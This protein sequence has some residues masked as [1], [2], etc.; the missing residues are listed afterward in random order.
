MFLFLKYLHIIGAIILVGSVVT[1][2]LMTLKFILSRKN[3]GLKIF[4]SESKFIERGIIVPSSIL[5]LLSGIIMASLWFGWPFWMDW[6]IIVIAFTG[7]TGSVT[8]PKIKRQL[9]DLISNGSSNEKL[10]RRLEFKFIIQI[11][12]DLILLFSVVGTMI[13]KPVF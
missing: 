5:T 8:I 11:G 7:F 6:G 3:P 4:Y 1:I 12:L 13:Y 10:I 2:D 9:T